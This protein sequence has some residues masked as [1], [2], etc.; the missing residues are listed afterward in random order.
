MIGSFG[1]LRLLGGLA[2]LIKRP[3]LP[4]LKFEYF[5]RVRSFFHKQKLSVFGR[6]NFLPGKSDLKRFKIPFCCTFCVNFV[7]KKNQPII[8]K[9]CSNLGFFWVIS[10]G[11]I[12]NRSQM[13][14]IFGN[15]WHLRSNSENR[16]HLQSIRN[17]LHLR[18]ISE[19][20]HKCDRFLRINLKCDRFLSTIA[21]AINFRNRSQMRS[22]S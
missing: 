17:W 19:N 16:S 13:R 2:R 7:L 9:H 18:S 11:I 3:K 12:N 4:T 5:F 20:D 22:I 6:S 21:N 15:Q 10:R 8:L 1:P 14:S